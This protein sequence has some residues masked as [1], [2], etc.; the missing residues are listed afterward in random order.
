MYVPKGTTV[1]FRN[2]NFAPVLSL[3]CL[4]SIGVPFGSEKIGVLPDALIRST[5]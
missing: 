1:L 4:M 3:S 2:S 5:S